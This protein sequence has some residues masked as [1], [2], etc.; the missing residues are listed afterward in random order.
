MA[1]LERENAGLK[2]ALSKLLARVQ[3]LESLVQDFQARLA[4]NS[5]NSS[6]PPSSDGPGA[7]PPQPPATPS[8][9]RR[10]GQPGHPKHERRLLPPERVTQTTTLLP[11]SCRCC[12][13]VL[14]GRDPSPHQHQVVEIP[15]LLAQAHDYW[16]HS[17]PCEDCQI[18][19]RAVLP[20]GVPAGCF[21]PRLQAMI[22]VCSG[23]YHLS[24][25]MIGEMMGD[26]FDADLSLGSVAN[27]EA[28]TS[29]ALAAPVARAAAHVQ[30]QPV[31][32]ADETGWTE[33]K[34]RAWLWVVVAAQVAVFLLDRRRGAQVA[35]RLLGEV[36]PGILISD[37][38]SAY[39]WI[40][41]GQ[42][43][44]CWA[45][46]IRHFKGFADYGEQARHLGIDLLACGKRM[47]YDWH[48]VR[49]A[50]L[51]RADFQH[52]MTPL[53][54]EILDLLRE[55]SRCDAPKV[56]GRC[57]EIL[58]LEGALFT[59]VR[60]VGVEPTNNVAERALRPAVLWRKGSFGTDS[61]QG[62]RFVERILTVVTTLRMQQ[63]NVLDYVTSACQAHLLG[64]PAPSL[65]PPD[66]LVESS[67]AVG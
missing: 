65:L 55:G 56:A 11:P 48:R 12:G 24:K 53:S 10:G 6:R 61:E 30:E 22:A 46:L 58:K 7:T 16:L 1:E 5:S 28:D 2:L 43:Q 47:F 67:P 13:K 26:F 29:A 33:A 21:G 3:V 57:R 8:G 54:G 20:A 41:A 50:T 66:A 44:I 19:T 32:H 39:N 15:R 23:Q 59:F 27:I 45:H 49:D 35:R 60:V 37:R 64:Q 51:T 42:R 31:Q 14:H 4:A 9:L 40:P 17:L 18:S 36:R 52:L 34:K 63:R 62:S 25:R 38:W